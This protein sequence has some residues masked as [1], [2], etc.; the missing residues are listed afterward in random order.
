MLAPHMQDAM[1]RLVQIEK[2]A[3]ELEQYRVQNL[4]LNE[5]K[6]K[7][8]ECLGAFRRQ[9]IPADATKMWYTLG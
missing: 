7:N 4:Q 6:E 5:R 3:D 9:E 2:M 1:S 8:R